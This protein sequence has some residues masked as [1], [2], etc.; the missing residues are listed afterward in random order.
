MIPSLPL[1]LPISLV[2]G[3]TA[4]G[5]AP[6]PAF[7][8]AASAA[9]SSPAADSSRCDPALYPPIGLMGAHP[10]MPGEWMLTYRAM[11]TSSDGLRDGTDHVSSGDVF[12][13]GWMQSPRSM[14]MEMHEFGVMYGLS[15]DLSLMASVPWISQSMESADP[16]GGS[17]TTRSSGFG[18][19]MVGASWQRVFDA[20]QRGFASLGVSLPTGST[21]ERDDMP[22]CP[23][24]KLEYVMQ[25]GS[26][27]FDLL[28][29]VAYT[30][31]RGAW[32][33]G[34]QLAYRLRLGRNEDEYRL[35]DRAEADAWV[36]R[37]W[38]GSWRSSLRLAGSG[39]GN[40]HGADPEIDPMM[41]PTND[42]DR[43]GGRRVD[44]ALGTDWFAGEGRTSGAS[45][46]IEF[47]VPIYQ[48]LDG[49]QL[50]TDWFLTLG[51][52]WSL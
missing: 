20:E 45:I 36:A 14:S 18:D 11:L 27:T 40:V 43:Q 12:G 41:S 38:S 29:A 6:A 50:E 21:D 49:P 10:H 37:R 8:L 46:G 30:A 22:G 9:V 42:P 31:V 26:G 52:R 13:E 35:G 1:L 15:E 4:P 3:T 24:C 44:L 34:A 28:P 47:G 48:D 17:F 32:S 23:D 2:S 19:L 5:L 25:T 51:L 7:D 33:L 16:M 39:W